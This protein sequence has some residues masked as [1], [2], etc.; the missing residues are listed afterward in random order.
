[1]SEVYHDVEEGLSKLHLSIP[2]FIIKKK[3]LQLLVLFLFLFLFCFF[4]GGRWRAGCEG[5][6][7]HTIWHVEIILVPTPGIE[8]MPLAMEYRQS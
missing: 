7:V 3:S 4:L 5:N 6:G 1:M 8:P 2:P